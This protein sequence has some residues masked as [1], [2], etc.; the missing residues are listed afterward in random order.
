MQYGPGPGAPGVVGSVGELSALNVNR[1]CVC[2][3]NAH[4]YTFLL[5]RER[6]VRLSKSVPTPGGAALKAPAGVLRFHLRVTL[7]ALLYTILN[8][9]I[10]TQHFASTFSLS[11][12]LRALYIGAPA[13]PRRAALATHQQRQRSSAE[14]SVRRGTGLGGDMH[15]FCSDHSG[16]SA[17]S[18]SSSTLS[19]SLMS[20]AE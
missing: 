8:E 3:R 16:T 17:S 11:M 6:K 10:R 18:G 2:E 13:A 7:T 19:N 20:F 4:T 1:E 5:T 14:L 15:M 12:R 9:V